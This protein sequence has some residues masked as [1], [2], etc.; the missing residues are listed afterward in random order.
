[1]QLSAADDQAL[2]AQVSSGGPP[3]PGDKG[4][5]QGWIIGGVLAFILLA[6]L[7]ALLLFTRDDDDDSGDATPTPAGQA[8]EVIATVTPESTATAEAPTATLAPE[9]P[10][11]T[12][13]PPTATPEP[14][15]TE[16]PPTETPEPTATATEEPEP[17][18]TEE[19]E[20]T[21]T[22]AATTPVPSPG[23][24][25]YEANWSGGA[26]D[27]QL[28]DGWTAENGVLVADGA[29]AQPL[30]APFQPPT[31][32]YAVEADLVLANL[33]QC[34]TI[35]GAFSHVSEQSNIGGTFSAGYVG[36]ACADGWRIDAVQQNSQNRDTLVEGDFA[37]NDQA[38]VYR[39][40]VQ[41][42]QIRLFIDGAFVGE[43]TDDRWPD[44]GS[45]G[46]Y[47]SGP[48]QVTVNAFRVFTL[49]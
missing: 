16:V 46:I 6:A 1:M 32:N 37:L 41:G 31:A 39:L 42:D 24:L 18:A 26:A 34:N 28:T 17:T 35:A 5:S 7:V 23:Q 30:L 49:P 9:E 45:A 19:P 3:P 33:D 40:E 8:T 25:A 2:L 29:V 10:T 21:A 14:T 15:A 4:P 47:L 44:A 48:L 22:E 43:A 36:G 38:H 20:P 27:W 11:A 12:P 13:E